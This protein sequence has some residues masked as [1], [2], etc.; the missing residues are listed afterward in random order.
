MLHQYPREALLYILSELSELRESHAALSQKNL[1]QWIRMRPDV[2]KRAREF[3]DRIPIFTDTRFIDC[4]NAAF[5]D[6]GTV[7][8]KTS[9]GACAYNADGILIASANNKRIGP[10]LGIQ[11][12][13]CDEI[14]GCIRQTIKT[15]VD[16]VIGECNHSIV[17]LLRELFD[18][19][20]TPKNLPEIRVYEAGFL[21]S[22]GLKPWWRKVSN[23]T[24][25]YCVRIFLTFGLLSVWGA[26]GEKE[27]TRWQELSIPDDYLELAQKEI[28][29]GG[30]R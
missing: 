11:A 12:P 9:F 29:E 26:V 16:Q 25:L 1:V 19:G 8:L 7:C 3:L 15:R 2:E 20:I 13:L 4:W 28:R 24:C 18:R 5:P 27:E 23:Y 30:L 22:D 14:H 10:C 21:V 17:W 6:D